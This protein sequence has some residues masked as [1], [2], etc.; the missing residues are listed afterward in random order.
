MEVTDIAGLVKGAAEGAGLGN[1]FLSEIRTVD[2]IFH[3]VRAFEDEVIAHVEGSVDPVR[4][5]DVITGEL[6]KKDIDF[7][8]G[9]IDKIEKVALRVDKSKKADLEILQKLLKHLED[10]K[11]ARDNDWGTK[12]VEVINPLNL[13]TAKP[14]VYLVNLSERDYIRKKNKHLLAI[15]KWVKEHSGADPIIP[16]CA[17]LEQFLVATPEEDGLK[18]LEEKKTTSAIPKIIQTGYKA[19]YLINFFTVGPD[20]VRAWTLRQGMK[21]PDAAGAIHTDLK[22]SFICAEVFS[23]DDIHELGSEA[24]V[25][26]EGRY[27]RRGK[28]YVVSDGDIILIKAGKARGK[29]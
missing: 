22:D 15:V 10:G 23:Y 12:E 18:Y 20:E 24:S 29:R 14:V 5:L 1:K 6:R 2:G 25:K 19:I 13:L 21:A 9:A 3:V 27:H 16:F 28:E 4:D 26:S 11:N 17:A 8:K 7:V